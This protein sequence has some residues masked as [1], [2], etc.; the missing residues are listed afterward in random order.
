MSDRGDGTVVRRV[1][2]WL[3]RVER[4]TRPVDEAAADAARRRWQ[5]LPEVARTPGQL[6]GRRSTGCEGTHGVFPACD[7]ACKPC[8]HSAEANRVRIDGPHTVTEVHE[9][10]AFLREQRGPAAYAQLIGGE[11]SLLEPDDHAAALSAMWSQGRIP[12]SMTHGDFDWDHLRALAVGPDGKRRFRQLSFAAHIDSTM[13]GRRGA[14]KP[15]SEAELHGHRAAFCALFG[16]LRREHGVRSYLA[17]NMTVTPDNLGE[18]ADVVRRS[19]RQGWRM[20]SFQPAAY[21]GNEGRWRDG[22]RSIDDD[23]VWA[24]ISAGAG[25]PRLPFEALQFGDTRCNRITWGAFVGERYVPLLDESDERDLHARDAYFAALPGNYL[26]ERSTAVKVL[27]LLRLLVRRPALAAI[28]V[29]YGLRFVGRAGGWRALRHGIRP[30]T[31]VM[32]R[33]MDAS[34]VA[35][36]WALLEQGRR[37]EDPEV[38][39]AQDRLEACVYAMSHPETGRIVPACVQHSVLDAEENRALAVLLPLPKRRERTHA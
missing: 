12:M 10:M 5:E 4:R 16:R 38:A 31:F 13:F 21:V 29:R 8:Y 15:A 19:R 27:R 2:R 1:L 33:F 37:A 11:V 24:Q 25:W 32:H 28:A 6:I 30:V 36:A 3:G 39:A 23:D 20:F 9:Q 22:F 34:V 14:P 7:F 35:P 26:A 17:H 18:V